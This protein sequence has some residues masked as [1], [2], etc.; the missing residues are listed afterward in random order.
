MEVVGLMRH[1]IMQMNSFHILTI[2]FIGILSSA[3]GT[4]VLSILE[5]ELLLDKNG[6]FRVE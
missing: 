6:C 1:R 5:M 4:E 2:G 3:I